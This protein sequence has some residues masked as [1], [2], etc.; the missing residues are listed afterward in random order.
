[1]L[2]LTNPMTIISFVGIFAGLGLASAVKDY[3]A[4]TLFV[5]GVFC[6]SALWWLLLSTG[7]GLLRTRFNQ[8]WMRWVNRIS[9]VIILAFGV[10]TLWGLVAGSAG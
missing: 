9:G 5:I 10:I 4:A 3:G 2:T 8:D 6:G 1:V 7:V